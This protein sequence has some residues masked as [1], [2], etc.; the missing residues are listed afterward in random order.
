MTAMEAFETVRFRMI[1]L[2]SSKL[3]VNTWIKR[4]VKLISNSA[5]IIVVNI[6]DTYELMS[7]FLIKFDTKTHK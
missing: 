3:D 2:R 5:Q 6:L 1:N 4:Q 7:N